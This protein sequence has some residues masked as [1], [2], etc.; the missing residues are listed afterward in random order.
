MTAGKLADVVAGG[1]LGY[2]REL[3][4]QR[5]LPAAAFA[6]EHLEPPDRLQTS[7]GT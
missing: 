7:S 6:G 1:H 5:P 3:V 4:R 2:E